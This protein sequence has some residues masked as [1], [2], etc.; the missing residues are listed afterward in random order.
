MNFRCSELQGAI[1]QPKEILEIDNC[2]IIPACKGGLVLEM[3]DCKL[4]FVSQ[5]DIAKVF[6]EFFRASNVEMRGTGLG[7]SIVKSLVEAHGG[8]IWVESPC[9]E[10]NTGSKFTFT[11]PKKKTGG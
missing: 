2:W 11:L 5:E 1:H 8:M 6:D 9:P 7:L 3:S 4:V 10:T